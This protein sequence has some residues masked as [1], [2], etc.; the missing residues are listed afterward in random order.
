MYFKIH[1]ETPRASRG[2][3]RDERAMLVDIYG[4]PFE[5]AMGST[6]S[7]HNIYAF[8]SDSGCNIY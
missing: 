7:T 1:A 6:L 8:L 3:A 4:L 2:P 5:K